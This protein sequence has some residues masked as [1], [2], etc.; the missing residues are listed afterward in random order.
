MVRTRA[1]YFVV[2]LVLVGMAFVTRIAFGCLFLPDLLTAMFVYAFFRMIG[3]SAS[4]RKIAAS[5]FGL[6]LLVEISQLYHSPLA[7]RLRDSIAGRFV[8]GHQFDGLD[9]VSFALGAWLALII[10]KKFRG[11]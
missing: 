6:C 8:L 1:G 5:A 7:D 4:G 11:C 10:D 9:I 3:I 2:F